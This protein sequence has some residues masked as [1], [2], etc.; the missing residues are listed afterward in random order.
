MK[1]LLESLQTRKK[2][3]KK[4]YPNTAQQKIAL[5]EI[6]VLE[7]IINKHQKPEVTERKRKIKTSQNNSLFNL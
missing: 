3:I 5:W 7:Q 1:A 4:H 6:D 2:Y